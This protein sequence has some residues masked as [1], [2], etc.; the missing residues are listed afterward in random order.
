MSRKLLTMLVVC[1]MSLGIFSGCSSESSQKDNAI[2]DTSIG[3]VGTENIDP[4]GKYEEPVKVTG[5]LSFSAAPSNV[6]SDIT[7]D[8]NTFI[9]VAEDM[10]NIDF[11]WLWTAPVDQYNQKLGVAMA[12]GELPDII[13]VNAIDYQTLLENEQIMPWNEVLPWASETL[14]EWIYRDPE[15]LETVTTEDGN[16]MAIPQYWDPKRNVNIMMIRTDWLEQVNM[17]I[18][19]TVEE[20]EA[21]ATAF[22][23]QIGAEVGISLSKDVLAGT[24]SLASLMNMVGSYPSAWIEDESG[25]LVPGEIQPETKEALAVL[26]RFYEKGLIHK[27]FALHDG[28]KIREKIMAEELG[29]FIAPWWGFDAYVGKEIAKNQDSK[30]ATVAI[31]KAPGTKGAIMDS[32]SIEKYWVINSECENPEAVMKLFNLFVKFE[33]E[34]PEEAKPENGFAW[35]W[36]PTQFFDPYD[37]DILH[38]AFNTQIATGDF[39]T[40]PEGIV[41]PNAILW[42]EAENYY[43]WKAGE[44]PYDEANKWGK[45]LARIDE[46]YAWGT[47]RRLVEE[48][49]YEIN[50][51]YGAPTETM[52][53]RRSTLDKLTEET[54]VKMVMGEMPITKFDEYVKS[55]LALGGEDIIEE[56]NEWHES[57]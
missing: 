34:Y 32:I 49:E 27:E 44:I 8:T 19:K 53:D 37:M 10:M 30:W 5:V 45:Y 38:E 20:L 21:V 31:P 4:F 36:V 7:P 22:K 26:N 11:E 47:T 40:V 13:G 23:E 57:K 48:E 29:I 28:T 55:W 56:V 43:K 15:V 25:E 35:N 6:P 3:K 42:E 39:N 14:T 12:S 24:S 9:T 18:P 16:I 41:G 33:T 54:Y 1:T 2:T 50:K 17:E 51:F 46:D 52:R